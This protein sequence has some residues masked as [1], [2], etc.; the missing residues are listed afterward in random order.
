M[1]WIETKILNVFENYQKSLKTFKC[2]K[3]NFSKLVDIPT[4]NFVPSPL[5]VSP[6]FA[7]QKVPLKTFS[8]L[9]QPQT[10]PDRISIIFPLLARVCF[11]SFC[12]SMMWS[13]Y[14]SENSPSKKYETVVS[15]SHFNNNGKPFSRILLFFS[16]RLL[17]SFHIL[18]QGLSY[19]K[20]LED[21]G[22]GVGRIFTGTT[23]LS[24]L[25]MTCVK[26]S[27]NFTAVQK[28]EIPLRR[29]L[30]CCYTKRNI[31]A[32][33]I[34]WKYKTE[35]SYQALQHRQSK[36]EKKNGKN[37][38]YRWRKTFGSFINTQ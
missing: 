24:F 33:W 31:F 18:M 30:L 5:P 15:L 22:R 26:G 20:F 12:V 25:T 10:K 4:S 28:K 19:E 8:S 34:N 17:L 29:I 35:S 13:H 9:T 16:F 14:R 21:A 36:I 1:F 23:C 27:T 7:P 2:F 3:R 32:Y 37:S 6:Q 11:I 38:F